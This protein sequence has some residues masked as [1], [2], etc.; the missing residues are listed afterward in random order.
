[1][2]STLMIVLA[3]AAWQVWLYRASGRRLW[4]PI[5]LAFASTAFSA[6]YLVAGAI[7]Y[8]LNRHDRFVAHTAWAGHVVWSEIGMGVIA[9]LVAVPLW[10]WGLRTLER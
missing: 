3:I 4:K 6:M 9:A 2:I 5:W 1:M 8:V 10:R 7:G